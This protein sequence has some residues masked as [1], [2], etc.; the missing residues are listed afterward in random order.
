[1]KLVSIFFGADHNM[2][3]GEIAVQ[4]T[5]PV[6]SLYNIYQLNCDLVGSLQRK[7]PLDM[8]L[9]F[10]QGRPEVLDHEEVVVALGPIPEDISEPL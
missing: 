2:L 6:E 7:L 8:L 10:F 9:E 4:N 3:S 1:M 5:F